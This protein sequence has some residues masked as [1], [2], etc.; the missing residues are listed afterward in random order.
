M[1]V[2]QADISSARTRSGMGTDLH[3][4]CRSDNRF[5]DDGPGVVVNGRRHLVREGGVGYALPVFAILDQATSDVGDTPELGDADFQAVFSQ[6]NGLVLP[7][8]CV[9]LS[10]ADQSRAME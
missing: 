8:M 3:R 5:R 6:L 2:R 1:H 7:A 10:R 4:G 9:L